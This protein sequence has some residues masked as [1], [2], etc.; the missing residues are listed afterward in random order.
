MEPEVALPAGMT[1]KD[2]DELCVALNDRIATLATVLGVSDSEAESL[3]HT[4]NWDLDQAAAQGVEQEAQTAAVVPEEGAAVP[5]STTWSRPVGR[6]RCVVCFCDVDGASDAILT[7]CGAEL[8][9]GC[10]WSYIQAALEDGQPVVPLCPMPSCQV[11]VPRAL[12]AVVFGRK[13]PDG[14][15]FASVGATLLQRFDIIRMLDFAQRSG[16]YSVCPAGQ[17]GKYVK[18]PDNSAQVVRCTCSHWYCRKCKLE[19]HT[20]LSCEAARLWMGGDVL[21]DTDVASASWILSFTRPC[22][23][24]GVPIEKYAGCSH[25]ICAICRQSFI[26]STAAN[27][28]SDEL[29][30]EALEGEGLHL[31]AFRQY[32]AR[33]DRLDKYRSLDENLTRKILSVDRQKGMDELRGAFA[34]LK[35][36]HAACGARL[37][38]Q[39]RSEEGSDSFALT[40][41]NLITFQMEKLGQEADVLFRLLTSNWQLAGAEISTQRAILEGYRRSLADT[42]D[43]VF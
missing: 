37:R 34:E 42:R 8:C 41:L 6:V 23:H 5:R 4:A 43:I 7:N 26:W 25:M 28:T 16:L 21:G 14:V 24:C 17:C 15:V 30:S 1:S 13:L 3:L 19:P 18:L 38:E 32:G 2:A 36:A 29:L 10:W 20:P 27:K 35:W 12:A 31:V 22:P 9:D 40:T 11:A 33:L 39:G